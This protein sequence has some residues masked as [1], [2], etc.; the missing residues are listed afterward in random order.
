MTDDEEYLFNPEE[1]YEFEDPQNNEDDGEFELFRGDEHEEGYN[2]VGTYSGTVDFGYGPVHVVDVFSEDLAVGFPENAVL[3]GEMEPI[4]EDD[5]VRVE[6]LGRKQGEDETHD[7]YH[8]Y[9]VKVG[10][11][12]E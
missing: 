10:R 8:N 5:V 1:E 12:K 3:E 9:D 4:E 6:Y 11:K 2:V 7:P